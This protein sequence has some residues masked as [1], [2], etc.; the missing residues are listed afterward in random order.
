MYT[1]KHRPATHLVDYMMMVVDSYGCAQFHF[2]LRVL[3]KGFG[4]KKQNK[5]GFFRPIIPNTFSETP[6]HANLG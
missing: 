6:H 4:L 3:R 1:L 5:T 2:A